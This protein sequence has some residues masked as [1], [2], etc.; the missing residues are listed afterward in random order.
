[1][2]KENKFKHTSHTPI[3][4]FF[5]ATPSV[6]QC[7]TPTEYRCAGGTGRT[8]IIICG[9]RPIHHSPRRTDTF[10]GGAAAAPWEVAHVACALLLRA[11]VH[12][13]LGC[14]EKL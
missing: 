7:C 13:A 10:R 4:N 9:L 5:A 2:I 6:S 11:S 3:P 8:N 12:F 14:P 1:M